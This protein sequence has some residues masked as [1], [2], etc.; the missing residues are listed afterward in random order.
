MLQQA[1]QL[2]ES[3]QVRLGCLNKEQFEID[4]AV[5]LSANKPTNK[6]SK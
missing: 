5:F 2:L 6:I 3:F 1:L 4:G